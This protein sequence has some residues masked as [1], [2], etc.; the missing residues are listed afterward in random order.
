MIDVII[1]SSIIGTAVSY[2]FIKNL[3]KRLKL[4]KIFFKKRFA[5]NNKNIIKHKLESE[6]CVICLDNY[7]SNCDNHIECSKKCYQLYCNHIFHK[8]CI[9]E[10]LDNNMKCPL[11]NLS[12]MTKYNRT[13]E[14]LQIDILEKKQLERR[15][16]EE[17][18]ARRRRRD[19]RSGMLHI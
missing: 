1:V 6:I 5:I 14:E 10:W 15:K 8:E 9:M 16:R 19:M 13:F 18:R 3:Y 17:N 7:H 11:C 4:K 12:I 2:I